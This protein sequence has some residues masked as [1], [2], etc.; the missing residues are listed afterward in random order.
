MPGHMAA[1]E[2]DVESNM[3]YRH[4]IVVLYFLAAGLISPLT[5]RA[6][7]FYVHNNSDRNIVITIE[8][9][10]EPS[11]PFPS[12]LY[13]IKGIPIVLMFY[14][15]LQLQLEPHRKVVYIS[16]RPLAPIGEI[17]N[18][19]YYERL[20]EIPILEKLKLIFK[21]FVI[22]DTKGQI[23]LTLDDI[24]ECDIVRM[25]PPYDTNIYTLEFYAPE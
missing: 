1:H 21:S 7:K 10:S 19:E 17:L 4:I 16:Y 12:Y 22:A 24:K 11:S 18:N 9:Y 2:K 8:F 5:L 3:K 25:P 23:L 6:E 13:D 14:D 20:E 15:S